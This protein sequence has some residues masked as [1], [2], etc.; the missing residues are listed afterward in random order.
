LPSSRPWLGF[1]DI[2]DNIERVLDYTRSMTIEDFVADQKTADATER[3]VLRI[4]EA[5]VKLDTFAEE[6]LPQHNWLAIRRIGNI[7]RHD[8]D[9]VRLA[10]IYDTVTMN[11]ESLLADLRKLI[12][13]HDTAEK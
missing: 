11:F 13:T 8:Y 6:M 1:G 9:R 12:A 7:L 10:M 2:V 4:S 3:C 5:A